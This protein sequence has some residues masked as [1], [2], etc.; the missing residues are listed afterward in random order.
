MTFKID[1]FTTPD[2]IKLRFGIS[3]PSLA[4]TSDGA[5]TFILIL[6]GRGEYIERYEE[7]AREL[8][9]RGLGCVTFDFRGQGGSQRATDDPQ[10][11]YVRDVSHYVA[12]TQHVIDHIAKT[13]DLHCPVA[14]THSTGG[15]V[16]MRML[17]TR[18]DQWQ[19]VIMIAPFFGLGGPDWL[20]I[21]AQFL[22]GGLCRYGFDK[23]FLP[24]QR[25]LSPTQPF[26]PD[27]LLTSDPKRYERNVKTLKNNPHLIIGGVSAGWLDACFRAQS[28]LSEWATQQPSTGSDSTT[29][30]NHSV[31]VPHLPPITMVLA[32]NDQ[33][34]SNS[35]TQSLFGDHPS[36][37]MI[38]IPEARHEILQEADHFRRQFW[39][40]FDDHMAQY[41]RDRSHSP[42]RE[43]VKQDP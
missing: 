23:Q 38:E 31:T 39:S 25:Q 12:D 33:V 10:M 32:G 7:T 19:S 15:L 35:V 34:V 30:K 40:A 17:S 42:A 8:A 9:Q 37:R 13:H 6:H 1:S 2:G 4:P 27:N 43:T 22:S 11:G 20:A 41:H 14:L 24:G 18:P 29:P 21:A 3:R 5:Q 16:A 28:Q 36:V 26:T